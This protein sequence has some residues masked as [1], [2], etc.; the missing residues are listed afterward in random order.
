MCNLERQNALLR[1]YSPHVAIVTGAAEGIGYAI[2]H[3]LAEDGINIA[4]NDVPAKADRIDNVVAE[5]RAKGRRALAIPGNVSQEVDVKWMIERTVAELG[6]LDIVSEL[7]FENDYGVQYSID[8]S[9]H[10][11]SGRCPL[12]RKY[13]L[14]LAYCKQ[15]YNDLYGISYCRVIRPTL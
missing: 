13:V 8:G 5:I 2:A 1:N 3:K 14:N 4:V 7:T 15:A 6:S 10:R 12:S 9:E 11:N